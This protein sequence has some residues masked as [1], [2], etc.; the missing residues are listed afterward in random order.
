MIMDVKKK[1]KINEKGQSL[2]EF[3]LFLPFMVMMYSVT[4]AISNSINASIN[5]QKITRAYFYYRNH[6]NS[7]V[8]K[9]RREGSDPSTGWRVFGQEIMGW[10]VK[11]LN[12]KNPVAACFKF[13]LPLGN[14]ADD[15]CEDSYTKLTTNFIRVQTVYGL[16]GA[17]YTKDGTGQNISYPRGAFV[18]GGEPRHCEIL[19]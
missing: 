5:Q 19:E 6:G 15:K 3:L 1:K 8:P 11:L 9:P 18:V 12:E 4:Q 17:T 7:T 14:E 13:N 16:C 2:I 10:S